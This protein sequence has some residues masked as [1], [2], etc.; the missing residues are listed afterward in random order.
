MR[1]GSA[2]LL[3]LL[4]FSIVPA[5]VVASAGEITPP[6]VRDL[7]P[8][9]LCTAN[10]LNLAHC[11]R[12]WKTLVTAG[13]TSA[14]TEETWN[15]AEFEG[16]VNGLYLGM[17]WSRS[18]AIKVTDDWCPK[19]IE[20]HDQIYNIIADELIAHSDQLTAQNDALEYFWMTIKRLWP[21]S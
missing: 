19:M 8:Q 13:T 1:K 5:Y 9:K 7:R 10:A 12:A 15:A 20:S 14:T 3:I 21:C 4:A 11:A 2:A 18:R 16:F 17:M 6:R